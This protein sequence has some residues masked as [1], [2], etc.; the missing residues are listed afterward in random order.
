MKKNKLQNNKALTLRNSKGFTLVETMVAVFILAIALT[1][2]LNLTA[3]SLFSA[4]YARNEI[5]AN[6]LMQEVVDYIRNQRDTTAFLKTDGSW[7]EFL[8]LFGDPGGLCFSDDGCYFDV[9][10][11]PPVILMGRVKIPIV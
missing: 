3:R 5:T 10:L 4:R 1:A 6:Y 9:N 11:E 8:T 2:L 7:Q